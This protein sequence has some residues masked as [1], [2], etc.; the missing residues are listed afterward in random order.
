M[1]SQ[2]IDS[3]AKFN[4]APVLSE[5]ADERNSALGTWSLGRWKLDENHDIEAR[6]FC[7]S[8][9]RYGVYPYM[10]NCFGDLQVLVSQERLLAT[11]KRH[12]EILAATQA[13]E[14]ARLD[15]LLQIVYE[16]RNAAA[17][18]SLL[19]MQ[20]QEAN[21]YSDAGWR[22]WREGA[23]SAVEVFTNV[24]EKGHLLMVNDRGFDLQGF[25]GIVEKNIVIAE[26]AGMKQIEEERRQVLTMSALVALGLAVGTFLLFWLVRFVRSHLAQ[27][28]EKAR[29]LKDAAA[30]QVDKLQAAHQRHKVRSVMMDETIREMTRTALSGAD[31]K[32]KE[33]LIGEL[34]K[35]I[36]SG[37]HELANALELALK[38]A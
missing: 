38:K 37:N 4:V 1:S 3:V 23:I 14:M 6:Y 17:M 28:K 13:R 20:I 9:Y 33:V 21:D 29:Q 12:R 27:A 18:N 34:R 10:A 30:G 31:A 5:F 15:P 35:A 32:S 7:I 16:Q 22:V 19:Q 26:R 2:S 8:G 25:K 36:E 24:R 11:H